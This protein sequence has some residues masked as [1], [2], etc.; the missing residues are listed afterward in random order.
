MT[1]KQRRENTRTIGEAIRELIEAYHLDNKLIETRIINAWTEVSGTYIAKQ[2]H[3]LYITDHVLYVVIFVVSG[4][5]RK[6]L[7]TLIKAIAL[8][9]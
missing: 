4:F 1:P 3:K 5:G 7:L 8:I 9:Y 6:G 2:T